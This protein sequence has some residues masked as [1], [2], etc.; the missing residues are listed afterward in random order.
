MLYTAQVHVKL[1]GQLCNKGPCFKCLAFS[2]SSTRGGSSCSAGGTC[3]DCTLDG[4]S[5]LNT[6]YVLVPV[7]P[8]SQL[9]QTRLQ[10][11]H[12]E[13]PHINVTFKVLTEI[14]QPGIGNRHDHFH[15]HNSLGKSDLKKI[16]YLFHSLLPGKCCQGKVS[17]CPAIN[18]KGDKCQILFCAYF[19]RKHFL[20]MYVCLF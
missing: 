2:D 15:Y 5:S 13:R 7:L 6:C 8:E 14:Y 1:L 12:G 17:K 16:C 4:S 20:L 9:F 10:P 11:L 19:Q 3:V 18:T